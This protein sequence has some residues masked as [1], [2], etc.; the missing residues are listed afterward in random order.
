MSTL[1]FSQCLNR[2]SEVNDV[3]SNGYAGSET[4]VSCHRN[5]TASYAATAH[6]N[7][8]SPASKQTIK[9]SFETDSNVYAYKPNLKVQMEERDS[10]LLQ[11]AYLDGREK[12]SAP[13]DIVVGS[14]RKAQTFLYWIDDQIYQL[15]VSYF[16]KAR[17]WV[18]SP[19]Y[20]ADKVRFDRN[21]PIGC[22]ECHGSYIKRTSVEVVNNRLSDHFD[23]NSILYGI[24]CERCHGPAAKHVAYQQQHPDEKKAKYIASFASLS[25]EDQLNMCSV[26]HSGLHDTKQTT[27]FFRPGAKLSAFI[28][29]DT[30]TVSLAD[31]DVH[32]NQLQ[33]LKSSECFIK[34]NTLNCS[35][36]HNTHVNERDDPA[37][38]SKRCMSCHQPDQDHFCKMA[39]KVGPSIVNNCI[40]CHMPT[41]E[42]KLITLRSQ[43]QTKPTPNLVRT[44]YIAVYPDE[45]KR[46]LKDR[47][48]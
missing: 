13:F 21:V 17:A 25:R 24:D 40:D 19:N 38:F 47:D 31:I 26:C 12:Q 48:R 39:E 33:L 1:F 28:H 8:T 14:G 5:F 23:K 46:F 35:T 15:P 37:L 6:H 44:H 45:T 42:S 32:G 34:S 16:V 2:Q 20:P 7:S 3:R 9:G 30:T 36:C 22:F 43:G 29:P 4:C 10:R 27:F 11:V 41:K 18:N